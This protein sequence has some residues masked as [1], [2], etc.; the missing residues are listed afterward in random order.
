MRFPVKFYYLL[1]RT[2]E[3]SK[4]GEFFVGKPTLFFFWHS[5]FFIL[6]YAFQGSP[7]YVLV[8]PSRD[9]EIISKFLSHFGIGTIRSS[10]RKDKFKGLREIIKVLENGGNVAITPDGPIGPRRKFKSGTVSLIR[11]LKVRVV[12]V[13]VAYSSFW[14]LD[15]WDAFRIPMPFSRVSIYAYEALPK[16]DKEAEKFLSFADEL[17]RSLL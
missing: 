7:V 6:P 15:T 14:E 2:L 16:D 5:N 4:F 17:A 9:G 3:I 10:Q 8:S 12:F 13:G 1:C 11:E